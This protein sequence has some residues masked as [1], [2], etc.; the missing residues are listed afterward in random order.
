MWLAVGAG[1]QQGPLVLPHLAST[2]PDWA[3][4]QH[5]G[6]KALLL[7]DHNRGC[8]MPLEARLRSHTALLSPQS[9]I[10][11]SHGHDIQRMSQDQPRIQ[12]VEKRTSLPHGRSSQTPLSRMGT[13]GCVLSHSVVSDS[14]DPVDCS[15]SGSS[16]HRIVQARTLG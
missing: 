3:S 13:L 9:V 10:Q 8:K 5:T 2:R 15:L 7:E 14:C 11:N 16:A 4:S 1:G 6:P 12:E